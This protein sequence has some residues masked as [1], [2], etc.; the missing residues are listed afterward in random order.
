MSR[1]CLLPS[2]LPPHSPICLRPALSEAAVPLLCLPPQLP[3][4]SCRL[5]E[6]GTA[7]LTWINFSSDSKSK[8]VLRKVPS[9]SFVC[10]QPILSLTCKFSLKSITLR[11]L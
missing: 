7:T 1:P 8:T 4:S 9:F 10:A 11:C 3:L 5:L 6:A 2:C